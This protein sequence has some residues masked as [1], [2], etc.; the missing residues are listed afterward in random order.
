MRVPVD[1]FVNWFKMHGRSFPW[2]EE[3]ISPFGIILAEV[4]LKQ[5]RAEMVAAVWPALFRKYPNAASLESASAEVLHHHISCLG[6]GR[7]RVTALRHLSAAINEAGGLPTE[8]GELMKLPYVGIYSAHAVACFAFGHPVP[9]V[10]LSIVRVLSRLAGIERPSDIRRAPRS[11][12]LRRLSCLTRKSRSTTTACWTSPR[13]HARLDHLDA[14]SAQLRPV[15]LMLT[16]GGNHEPAAH[17]ATRDGRR[18]CYRHQRQLQR[19]ARGNRPPDRRTG[20]CPR[21]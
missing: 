16:T 1:F 8:P 15:A 13:T 2:R 3:D 7:Q 6:F 12:R 19:F 17:A 14:T 21:H 9:I 4:L 20:S 10:D 18:A 5:T 11:G